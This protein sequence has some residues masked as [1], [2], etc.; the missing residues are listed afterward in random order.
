MTM[1]RMTQALLTG[2]S[3]S[4]GDGE[5]VHTNRQPLCQRGCA[6]TQV[7]GVLWE[8]GLCGK[9]LSL[10]QSLGGGVCVSGLGGSD[11]ISEKR[12]FSS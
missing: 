1:V 10:R 9:Q 2:S 3:Q 4:A 6:I 12:R 8:R 5:G 11:R 7:Y